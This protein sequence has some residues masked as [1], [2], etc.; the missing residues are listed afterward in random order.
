MNTA[1]NAVAKRAGIELSTSKSNCVLLPPQND[2]TKNPTPNNTAAMKTQ[3]SVATNRF[4]YLGHSKPD[5]FPEG[6]FPSL[7]HDE[8]NQSERQQV[9]RHDGGDGDKNE[10]LVGSQSLERSVCRSMR[11]RYM[12]YGNA[13]MHR[14]KQQHEHTAEPREERFSRLS[15]IHGPFGDGAGSGGVGSPM[16]AYCPRLP[17]GS[18]GSGVC[19]VE[20][21]FVITERVYHG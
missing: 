13:R 2:V 6:L 21:S 9:C 19:C 17:A 4:V 1:T 20:G 11:H 3:M 10:S 18:V 14:H 8:P 16:S 12:K 7:R 5:S 15:L